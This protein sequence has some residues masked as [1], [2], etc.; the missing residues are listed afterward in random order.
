MLEA[1]ASKVSWRTPDRYKAALREVEDFFGVKGLETGSAQVTY[2]KHNTWLKQ[3]MKE[4]ASAS[5]QR[6]GQAS[7][8]LS[9]NTLLT[10][11]I[12][13]LSLDACRQPCGTHIQPSLRCNNRRSQPF[14]LSLTWQT[15]SHQIPFC[16]FRSLLFLLILGCCEVYWLNTCRWS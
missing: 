4:L 12:S 8:P 15:L 14:L 16:L 6:Q 2:K 1:L 7:V 5:A 3:A 10:W 9:S 13:Q 11:P